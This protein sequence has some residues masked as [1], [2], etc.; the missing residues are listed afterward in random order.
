MKRLGIIGTL[1]LSSACI[2]FALGL[3]VTLYSLSQ[4]R[5]IIYDQSFRGVEAQAFNWIEENKV[6]INITRDTDV[7]RRL[8]REFSERE[9][10]AY[11]ALNNGSGRVIASAR[12]PAQIKRV[13]ETV[14]AVT[15]RARV[16]ETS[17]AHGIRYFEVNTPVQQAGMN[18]DLDTMFDLANPAQHSAILRIGISRASL[19]DQL[20][21]LLWRNTP[22]YLALVSLALAVEVSLVRRFVRPLVSMGS[23]ARR[24]AAGDLSSRVKDGVAL[25]NE[26]GE[27]VRNF[28]EMAERMSEL[29]SGLEQK[30][31]ERTREL[32]IANAKLRELDSVKSNFLST[33]SHE[34][35]TPLTSVKAFA[36]ILLDSPNEDETTRR[37]FLNIIDT[38]SDRLARLISDLLDLA[39]IESGATEWHSDLLDLR[40]VAH[41]ACA[42]MIPASAERHISINT[43]ASVAFCAIGDRDRLQQ[44]FTNLLS[45]ALKFCPQGARVSVSLD[46]TNMSGPG[47]SRGG[48]FIEASVADDGPGIPQEDC[49]RLFEPFY[50]SHTAYGATGTGLGLAIC[51]EIVARHGG[52]IWVESAP[53]RGSTFRF[54][55]R[56]A[57]PQS[58]S[59]GFDGW[60]EGHAT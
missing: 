14:V 20:T 59:A 55:V 29:H 9:G 11:V 8:I 30:V 7:L 15:A 17:D 1:A 52:E 23:A 19:E 2:L 18:R 24:I 58:V 49:A 37:R 60:E 57:E 56:A 51:R 26:V 25:S 33:V 41:A 54:T 35:R 31:R 6:P 47:E 38:E 43:K 48:E 12:V 13:R 27:L 32:E 40:E 34:F 50:R 53:Q 39:K 4:L 10:I 5:E 45:N 28:N 36:Q 22:L 42:T 3:L 44:V 46:R 21:A 16:Y